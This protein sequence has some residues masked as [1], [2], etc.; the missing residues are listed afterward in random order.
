MM[1]N[2]RILFLVLSVVTIVERNDASAANANSNN[3]IEYLLETLIQKVDALEKNIANVRSD[4]DDVNTV[5]SKTAFQVDDLVTEAGQTKKVVN[6]L[7]TDIENVKKDMAKGF[8]TA[9]REMEEKVRTLK[10]DAIYIATSDEIKKY[11]IDAE[12]ISS[13]L[14]AAYHFVGNGYRGNFDDYIEK[15]DL[16]FS[17]CVDMCSKKKHEDG[18]AWNSFSWSGY[19]NWCACYKGER[20]HTPSARHVHFRI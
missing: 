7:V 9:A 5:V 8:E 10:A 12:G 20:G 1:M 13:A 4:V 16:T 6:D 3:Q 14:A 2:L 19:D 15:Y 17:Q 18:E 11:N